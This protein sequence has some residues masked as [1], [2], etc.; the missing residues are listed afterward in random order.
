MPELG[1]K[2]TC[3]EC[4]IKFYDLGRADVVCPKCG[5]VPAPADDGPIL[6]RA[7]RKSVSR[8]VESEAPDEPEEI[9]SELEEGDAG[10]VEVEVEDLDIEGDDEDDDSDD[11]ED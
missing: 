3:T 10:D 8:N 11:D 5:N 7:S 9:T 1:R 4:G 6:K 2:I